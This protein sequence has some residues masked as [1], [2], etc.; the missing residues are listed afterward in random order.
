MFI[1]LAYV[2]NI[3]KDVNTPYRLQYS[4]FSNANI[5]GMAGNAVLTVGFKI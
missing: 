3:L 1:D 2:H 5:K 4:P